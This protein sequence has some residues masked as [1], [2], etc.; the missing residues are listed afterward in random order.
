MWYTH[1][2]IQKGVQSIVLN[3]R[4][5]V[6]DPIKQVRECFRNGVKNEPFYEFIGEVILKV[7]LVSNVNDSKKFIKNSECV[8][9]TYKNTP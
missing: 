2:T 1:V 4:N 7:N 9:I 5:S 3:T 8:F 6:L